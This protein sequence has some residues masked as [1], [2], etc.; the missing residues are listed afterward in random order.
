[1]ILSIIVPVYNVEKYLGRCIDSLIAQDININD[2]EIIMVNDGSTDNSRT[3]AEQLVEK[4]QNV[5]L[6]NQENRGL[7][8]ARNT[9]M[10][11][12]VGKY[13]MFVDSD[14]YLETNSI[15]PIIECAEKYE[16]DVC[17]FYLKVYRKDGSFYYGSKHPFSINEVFDGLS[18]VR[19]GII[20]GSVC[21]G[22]YLRCFLETNNLYFHE[23]ITHEDVEFN[24][25]LF[26]HIKRIMFTDFVPYIYF[27]NG[28]SLN[29]SNDIVKVK[30]AFL[31]DVDVAG[32][33]LKYVTENAY[34]KDIV[35]LY[36][37]RANS[38]V[39]SKMLHLLTNKKRR[40]AFGHDFMERLKAFDL[41]PIKGKT[42]SWKTYIL[43]PILN[44]K[45]IT[46]YLIKD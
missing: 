8:G 7:A 45:G 10:R 22:L 14:D 44:W 32:Y 26:L 11:H 20:S 2:Y 24:N 46:N 18:L 9:G 42:L 5:T 27:W 35:Q 12:A 33:G 23:G 3:I 28:E 4:Y 13:L 41:Y 30:K 16:L 31:D 38:L 29:R 19:K 17:S 40:L 25:R 43:I 15:H 34:P 36:N 6:Y 1:M 37:R 21:S 39:V